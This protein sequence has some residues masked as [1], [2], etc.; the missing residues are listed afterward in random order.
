MTGFKIAGV[1]SIGPAVDPMIV[2]D[3]SMIDPLQFTYGFEFAV[4]DGSS[5]N[6]DLINIASSKTTGFDKTNFKELPLQINDPRLGANFSVAF[7]PVLELGISLLEIDINPIVVFADI[8]KFEGT[9][10]LVPNGDATCKA[11]ANGSPHVS[12]NGD[13]VLDIGVGI[14]IKLTDQLKL[15]PSVTLA[16]AT[17]LPFSTCFE[18]GGLAQATAPPGLPANELSVV[19]SGTAASA[20][21]TAAPS[22]SKSVAKPPPPI[23]TAAP[24]PAVSTV[25]VVPLPAGSPNA[26]QNNKASGAYG[27]PQKAD[28]TNE[29]A[30]NGGYGNNK[31]VQEAKATEKEVEPAAST[32]NNN[33]HIVIEEDKASA[34]SDNSHIVIE[35][36][37]VATEDN[38]QE[39]EEGEEEDQVEESECSSILASASATAAA[40]FT[41]VKKV[42]KPTSN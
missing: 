10:Q 12:F 28:T 37:E 18:F 11:A 8:P 22:A 3:I 14:D 20:K 6:V 31:Q 26:Q 7:R 35:E 27:I 40:G 36:N 33:S 21:I 24:A 23:Q 39:D 13:F 30:S 25:T 19:A 38:E 17:L 9:I 29:K 41:T 2:I 1:V 4:P 15:N 5:I 34:Q 16:E 42:V 32:Q